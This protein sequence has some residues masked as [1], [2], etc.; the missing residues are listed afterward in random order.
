MG[1]GSERN[2][3]KRLWRLLMRPSLWVALISIVAYW[4]EQALNG[5]F[6]YD[7]SGRYNISWKCFTVSLY[8]CFSQICLFDC[9][10]EYS[11]NM[12]LYVS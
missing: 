10:S 12:F 2:V 9:C 6:V 7:D 11:Y 5:T 8:F 3:A 4:D 1:G